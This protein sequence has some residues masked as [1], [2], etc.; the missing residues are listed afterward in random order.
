MN[1]ALVHGRVFGPYDGSYS[2][3]GLA[4]M[5]SPSVLQAKPGQMDKLTGV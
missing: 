3:V 4:G 2:N 5:L 1:I